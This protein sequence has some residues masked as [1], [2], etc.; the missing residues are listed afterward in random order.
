MG[1]PRGTK[2]TLTGQKDVHTATDGHRLPVGAYK[3]FDPERGKQA[4]SKRS[5]EAG[6]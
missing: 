4:G 1:S 2:P 3:V 6:K 5:P